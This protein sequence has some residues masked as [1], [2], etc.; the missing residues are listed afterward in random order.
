MC[1][2][3]MLCTDSTRKKLANSIS[4]PFDPNFN[5]NCLRSQK[6]SFLN[7][8]QFS[9]RILCFQKSETSK[10]SPARGSGPFRSSHKAPLLPKA[11][12]ERPSP[13]TPHVLT[14]LDV[15]HQFLREDSK[16]GQLLFAPNVRYYHLTFLC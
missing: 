15:S 16:R 4:Q 7:F 13:S 5:R 2:L 9:E 11:E 14:I 10:L 12:V 1:V 6:Y 8:G 3:C